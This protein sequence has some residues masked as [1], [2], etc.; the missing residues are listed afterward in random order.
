[1]TCQQRTDSGNPGTRWRGLSA[2]WTPAPTRPNSEAPKPP[3]PAYWIPTIKPNA[4]GKEKKDKLQSRQNTVHDSR[5]AHEKPANF[6]SGLKRPDPTSTVDGR[7]ISSDAQRQ[8]FD[9]IK[10]NCCTRCHKD[11]HHRAKCPLPAAKWEEK[12]DREKI[13]Y[14][15]SVL[16]WQAKAASEPKTG[17]SPSPKP[18]LI[19]KRAS[20]HFADK[21]SRRTKI[22]PE[23]L[24]DDDDHPLCAYAL[25]P[26]A[27]GHLQC[28]M[29][30][31]SEPGG[32]SA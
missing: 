16:K 10:S 31:F 25:C 2:L 6:P 29:H 27:L 30:Y 19:P 4:P 18:T 12:F 26:P 21:E 5:P 7:K 3:S 17:T 14:W 9:D 20:V 15:E 11:D 8:L 32:Q 24:S 23:Y 22:T 28:R 13:K 1:M